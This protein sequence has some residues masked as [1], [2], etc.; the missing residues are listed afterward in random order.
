MNELNSHRPHGST[1]L[2][3]DHNRP[4]YPVVSAA[5]V[6]AGLKLVDEDGAEVPDVCCV[7]LTGT[8]VLNAA[9]TAPPLPRARVA[10][11]AQRMVE[12]GSGRLVLVID[13]QGGV[14]SG[15]PL[16]EV[17]SRAADLAWWRHMAAQVAPS[18]VVA[19]QMR[20]GLAP[21]LGH[22]PSPDRAAAIVR[23]LPLRRVARPIDLAAGVLLL[24]S[25]GCSYTV[26][27]TIPIDGGMDLS[28]IP[29]L[30]TGGS[31]DSATHA[32]GADHDP[33]PTEPVSAAA[34]RL[35]DL[36]GRHALVV[37]ASSGIGRATAI[38]LARRGA[39]IT[40]VARRV[41]ALEDAADEVR[42]LGQ[43]AWVRCQDVSRL[44]DLAG[45]VDRC[46]EKQGRID[47]MVYATGLFAVDA[48]GREAELRNQ[49]LDVN[50]HAYAELTAA[51]VR[52]WARDH[53]GG[54]VVGIC[55]VGAQN[56][57]IPRMESYGASKAA[58]AQYTRCVAATAGRFGVR[59]NCVA[60]G[61][62]DTPMADVV[63]T[64]FH[65]AWLAR[66]PAGRAGAPQDVAALAAYLASD[67]SAY[68]TGALLHADGGYALGGLPPLAAGGVV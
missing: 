60:P 53:R 11:L 61:I 39:D 26:A 13:G 1:G 63:S 15:V 18:G 14:H 52:R 59:A 35:Y 57:P 37:G 5:F 30:H 54:S 7:L 21:S 67:A 3:L 34:G 24:S 16:D 55:S 58:M 19:N 6:G 17:A 4:G 36:R 46:W 43:G 42:A 33:E 50:Y 68:V 41:K 49:S 22:R 62:V 9:T 51:L 25:E 38:E 12:R 45:L 56:V 64:D 29:P 28:L 31:K 10:S 2:I 40:L 23:H 20:V 48:P 66:I 65:R 8:S 27:E 44:S 47:T 32:D